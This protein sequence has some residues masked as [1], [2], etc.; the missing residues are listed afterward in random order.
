MVSVSGES[1]AR[2]RRGNAHKQKTPDLW[3]FFFR[4]GK[5]IDGCAS[6]LACARLAYHPYGLFACAQS[7][8]FFP[9]A[10]PTKEFSRPLFSG[11][12]PDYDIKKKTTFVG[13]FL[14]SS[15]KRDSDPRPRPW[16]GRALPTELF[17]RGEPYIEI[18]F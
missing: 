16:Q 11:P 13:G 8:K 18:N 15:G 4:A 2:S 6:P 7:P 12:R 9:R 5:G 3:F 1:I 10:L 14:F 17:P